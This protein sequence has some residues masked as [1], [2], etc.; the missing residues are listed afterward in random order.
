MTEFRS[1]VERQRVLLKAEEWAKGVKSL[2]IH[3][4]DSMW[5]DTRPQDTEDNK[6][7]IDTTYN[8]GLIER[9]CDDGYT[10]YFGKELQGDEL[11]DLY[12]RTVTPSDTQQ[13]ML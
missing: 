7:V 9:K 10:V 1:K 4:I 2:H 6:S 3:S 5:Y 11:I 13:V 12:E 8:S